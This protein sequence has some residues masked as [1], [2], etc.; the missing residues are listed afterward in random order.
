MRDLV[1]VQTITGLFPIDGADRIEKATVLGWNVVVPKGVFSVGDKVAYFEVDSLLN[2]ENEVFNKF[3]ERGQKTVT[4]DG[5]SFSGHVLRTAKLRGVISQGLIMGL[6]ELNLDL[7]DL[8]VLEVDDDL[9]EMVGVVKWE[10]PIPT[11]GNI[12]GSFDT[13]FSPKT[14]ATR[15]QTISGR[16]D[17]IVSLKWVPSVKV[18]GTSQTL[19]NDNGTIRVFGRNWEQSVEAAGYTVAAQHGII[20][21]LQDNEGMAIQFE[22]AGEGVQSNRLKLSEKRPFIFAVWLKG[23]KVA[24]EDWDSRLE[25]VATPVLGEEWA[26]SGSLEEMIEKVSGLRGSVTKDILDEG[27]V[28]H[29]AGGQVAPIWMGSNANFKIISNKYLIKHKL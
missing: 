28:F 12:I 21:V 2:A 7:D 18:D 14:S 24:R 16:W 27:I 29:L 26:P 8:S 23:E 5:D 25:A 6:D 19:V 10:E 11:D 9:T 3:Q 4:I 20:D 22:L 13:R 17:E 1:T 15:V